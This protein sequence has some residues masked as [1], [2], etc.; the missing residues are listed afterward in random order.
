MGTTT[1][2][3]SGLVAAFTLIGLA[4]AG[5]AV[6]QGG[7]PSL[8]HLSPLEEAIAMDI[9]DVTLTLTGAIEA[10]YTAGS[11]DDEENGPGL[12]GGLGAV[13]MTQLPNRWRVELGYAGQFVSDE[14]LSS[15]EG[16]RYTDDAALSVG[17]VWGTVSLGNVSETVRDLTRRRRAF[18]N[19]VLAFD[20]FHGERAD[21]S[22]GYAGRVG[23]FVVSGV[24][25]DDSNIDLGLAFQRPIG[26]GSRDY[27]F[28][29][30]AGQGAY[31]AADDSRLFTSRGYSV[32]G[33][34]VYGSTLLDV[35]MG[36]E[37][38]SSA[39]VNATRWYISSGIRRKIMVWGLSLEGHYGQIEGQEE[40]SA[41]LGVQ[42][43]LARGLS[44]KFGLNYEAAQVE[45]GD[46]KFLDSGDTKAALSFTYRF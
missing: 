26:N 10:R 34:V 20:D 29:F 27:R 24:V 44:A 23:P 15:E 31:E 37:S 22:A 7:L 8:G 21:R 9:G 35:G 33:E 17:G 3:R 28:T 41:A 32:V 1:S 13:A 2:R 43:D 30:R 38:F 46:V 16:K 39:G 40:V 42:Y 12:I 4:G 18:G 14:S 6:A 11:D 36:Q 19:A 25:G 45:L 5:P